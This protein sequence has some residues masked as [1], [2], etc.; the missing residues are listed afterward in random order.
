MKILRFVEAIEKCSKLANFRRQLGPL[1]A[2]TLS[3]WNAV[4]QARIDLDQEIKALIDIADIREFVATTL[5]CLYEQDVV[6]HKIPRV[7]SLLSAVNDWSR[8]I[9][10]YWIFAPN[11]YDVRAIASVFSECL[12]EIPAKDESVFRQVGT[13]WEIDSARNW[14]VYDF[15]NI[16]WS[17]QRGLCDACKGLLAISSFDDN[18]DYSATCNWPP[19][20]V[21]AEIGVRDRMQAVRILNE[22]LDEACLTKIVT[23]P[24]TWTDAEIPI[25]DFAK[26]LREQIAEPS[27]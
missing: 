7:P 8:K 2:S 23:K 14:V 27:S 24:T 15:E 26:M 21:E 6:T 12:D 16:T 3:T 25:D 13:V 10:P 1:N 22:V 4:R 11:R 19:Q 5:R 9:Q 17:L 20:W 18:V